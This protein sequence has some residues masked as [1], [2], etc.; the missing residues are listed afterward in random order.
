MVS[1]RL[2]KVII[3][4][5]SGFIGSHLIPKLLQSKY[6]VIVFGR[7]PDTPR[8]LPWMNSVKFYQFNL[9]D[10]VIPDIS[11]HDTGL[12]HL[13]WPGLPNYEKE[14]HL[15][16]NLPNSI[17]FIQ[18][19]LNAGLKKVL[20][21]G[22][23]FEY[24]MK[25]GKILST[26]DPNPINPYAKAKDKLRQNLLSLKDHY[27]FSL[28]WARLFYMYGS[29]QN[30]NSIIAQ[31]DKAAANKEK[32][33]NMSGGAQLRDYLPVSEVADQLLNLYI[34]YPEGTYNICSGKPISI[35]ELVKNRIHEKKFNID[36]N[37]GFY[38]YSELE[39]MSFWGERDIK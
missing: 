5:G 10:N 9:A 26:D 8:I 3:T 29:G 1:N 4:G 35:K 17:N 7:D 16:E 18:Q 21:S 15:K 30:P 33:F 23:C 38:E 25:E 6:E 20:V 28:Q 19:C 2:K 39:P 22:T 37:L 34:H 36:L 12:I 14:F 27:E 31:L 13:A 11:M 24:G 32:I